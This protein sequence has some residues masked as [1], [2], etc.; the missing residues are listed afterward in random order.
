MPIK[1]DW[2]ARDADDVNRARR[3]MYEF[4]PLQHHGWFVLCESDLRY[5]CT[6]YFPPILFDYAK[7]LF[8][9]RGVGFEITVRPSDGEKFAAFFDL[10]R[11]VIIPIERS[12]YLGLAPPR[13]RQGRMAPGRTVPARRVHR[14]QPEP[15]R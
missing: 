12:D 8:P 1:H 6:T 3:R 14:D 4:D 13:G 9:R 11:Q 15:S 2:P 5:Y 10:A 7:A